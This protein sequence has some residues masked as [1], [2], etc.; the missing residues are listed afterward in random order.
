MHPHAIQTLFTA[1]A[2]AQATSAQNMTP[3]GSDLKPIMETDGTFN[4]C[5]DNEYSRPNGGYFCCEGGSVMAIH[6]PTNAADCCPPGKVY[7]NPGCADPPLQISCP[8][9]QH[10]DR[11]ERNIIEYTDP[12]DWTGK[13][14]AMM[15][16]NKRGQA[17]FQDCLDICAA[18]A[19][20]QGAN[21]WYGKGMCGINNKKQ[22]GSWFARGGEYKNPPDVAW[23]DRNVIAMV[24]VPQ[25]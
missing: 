12:L 10:E 25:R 2:W 22:G 5:L 8:G 4:V 3:E 18:D 19:K 7:T 11:A 24:A 21:W 9:I 14:S 6:P 20:C 17:T 13:M 1:W 16:M 15:N 23:L